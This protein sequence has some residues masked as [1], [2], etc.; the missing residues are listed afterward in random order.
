[1]PGVNIIVGQNNAG[2]ATSTPAEPDFPFTLIGDGLE[3]L[4]RVGDL[5]TVT[6]SGGLIS[7]VDDQSGNDRHA[8]QAI[9][10]LRPELDELTYPLGAAAFAAAQ[11]FD[12]TSDLA[13]AMPSDNWTLWI[14]AETDDAPSSQ[15][16]LAIAS[17]GGYALDLEGGN[18]VVRR[19]GGSNATDG[20][21]DGL[22]HLFV[23]QRISGSVHVMM[24]G[25]EVSVTGATGVVGTP[26]GGSF[27]GALT[28][29]FFKF[30]GWAQEWA[31]VSRVLTGVPGVGNPC[32][33]ELAELTDYYIDRY[34]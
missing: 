19:Q 23:V 11:F 1:M 6:E 30:N 33:G 3:H 29:A 5:D 2:A 20:A 31:A 16:L 18:R 22:L 7:Q 25:I 9:S 21:A 12:V 14:V 27:V 34:V 28:A 4:C 10:L 13:T 8:T 17:L 26:S 32:T 15:G 24:D